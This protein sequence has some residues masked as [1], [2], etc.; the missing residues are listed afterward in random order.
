M[1]THDVAVKAL[2]KKID[3]LE[4]QI[5]IVKTDPLYAR[6]TEKMVN[7]FQTEVVSL[8]NTIS[9]IEDAADKFQEIEDLMHPGYWSAIDG[10]R[11][12]I[13]GILNSERLE[14]RVDPYARG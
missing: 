6:H 10:R 7:E 11:K 4:I 3:T 14:W 8:K 2:N 1:E 5:E 9:F 12:R 13:L